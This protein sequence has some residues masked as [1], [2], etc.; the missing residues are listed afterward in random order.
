M[1]RSR[2]A[3]V[4]LATIGVLALLASFHTS[5]GTPTRAAGSTGRATATPAAG[6]APPQS[7]TPSTA[8]APS[9][10]SPAPSGSGGTSGTQAPAASNTGQHS[11]DG[12]TVSTQYGD[13]QVQ[14]VV[15]GS[16]IVDVQ[17]L[18]LPNDRSRSVRISDYAGP[19]LRQEAL[20][21]QSAN[22]NTVSGATYTSD[23][24]A[25]SLQSALDKAG[26]KS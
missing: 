17:A 8:A 19:V 1:N 18:A 7:T 9:G 22:I 12:D 10:G 23:G 21:A 6:A 2:L 14:I 11:V 20:Q 26:I 3:A 15:S 5:P 13:V 25:Q 24:Y 16:R 4:I